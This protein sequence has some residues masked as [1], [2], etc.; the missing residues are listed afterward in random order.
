L[1][2]GH[3]LFT[4]Q[5]KNA[6]N[7][8]V[9]ISGVS[10]G[11]IFNNNISTIDTTSKEITSFIFE[12]KNNAVL[13]VNVVGVIDQNNKSILAEVPQ[14]LDIAALIPTIVFS[15]ITISPTNNLAQNFFDLVPFTVTALDG[16]TQQ[17]TVK[18]YNDF[19]DLGDNTILE[20]AS[21]KYNLNS[22]S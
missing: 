5:H 18:A 7:E 10:T 8:S 12:A 1:E 20:S 11:L 15:G 17:Y 2:L 13:S 9:N 3:F 16:S 21:N 22:F 4:K 14:G 6:V 19:Y